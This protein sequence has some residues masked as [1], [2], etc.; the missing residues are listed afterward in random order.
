MHIAVVGVGSL[1]AAISFELLHHKEVKKLTLV[2]TFQPSVKKMDGEY[3]DLLPV[4]R[5]EGIGLWKMTHIPKG[6]DAIIIS[7]G[8]PRKSTSQS[9]ADLYADNLP[10]LAGLLSS[11]N[12]NNDTLVFIASNPPNELAAWAKEKG[13]DAYPL[14]ACTD[15]LRQKV[16]DFKTINANVLDNK[17][18]TQWT[19]AYAIVNET[20]RVIKHNYNRKRKIKRDLEDGI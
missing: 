17:G 7:A 9:K 3:W 11:E 6:V 20:L 8:L 15:D 5:A 14:R 19:A 18:T 16:G 10:I 1:G 13:Y 2:E 12:V 4:A